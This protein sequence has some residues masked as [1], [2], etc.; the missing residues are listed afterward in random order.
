MVIFYKIVNMGSVEENIRNIWSRI[1]KAA[2]KTGRDKEDIKLVA[3]TK[4]VEVERIK[5]AIKCGIETI[6]ENRVQ[7]AESKFVQITEK[8]EK[9]LIGH[10]QTN[11]AK[12]AVELFDFIQSV[13]SQHIAQEI[14]RRAFQMGKAM[15]VL[16]EI[17]TSGEKSKFGVDPD[18]ALSFVKLILNSE[19]IKIKGLMTIGLFSDN[20]E[21]TRPCFK[22]LKAIFDQ[23]KR[24][25]LPNVEMKYLSMGMTNDF[26]IAIQ[27]G[28]NMVRIGTGIFGPRSL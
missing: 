12:K 26:E 5:E 24:E 15:E 7:E 11:K 20:S 16:V 28:S 4:T 27:E 3:V 14:S 13:D 19:G 10:L 17:N 18:Q 2:E 25:S 1:E 8:V 21:D 22:K 6:G 9:H 23:M